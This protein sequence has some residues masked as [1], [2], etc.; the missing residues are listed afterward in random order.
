M[1]LTADLDVEPGRQRVDDGAADA[2]QTT[3]DGVPAAAE[4]ATGVQDREDD[5]DGGTA[6]AG[7]DVD[8]DAAAVVDHAHATVGEQGD[9]DGVAV[10]GQASSTELSTIS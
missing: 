8:G 2:V 1:A 9:V 7:H 6:L 4:L 10:A 5:L 3:G